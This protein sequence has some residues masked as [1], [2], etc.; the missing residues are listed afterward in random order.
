LVFQKKTETLRGFLPGGCCTEDGERAG[1]E[2]AIFQKRKIK[3]QDKE[4]NNK[5]EMFD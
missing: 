3:F 1:E 5:Y 2:A 4:S